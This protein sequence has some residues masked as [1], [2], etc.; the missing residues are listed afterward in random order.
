MSIP[1]TV[2]GDQPPESLAQLL[3]L[4][5]LRHPS[6]LAITFI[7]DDG[8]TRSLTYAELLKESLRTA[9]KLSQY[10]PAGSRG[11]L[12]YPP[13]IDFLIGFFGCSFAGWIPVPSCFPKA[14]RG[15]PRLDSIANNCNPS[16]LLLD[17]STL[18]MVDRSKWSAVASAL[19]YVTTDDIG[20]DCAGDKDAESCNNDSP[21]I[22]SDALQNLLQISPLALL[23]YTSGSTSEP[24]GVMVTHQNMMANLEAIREGFKI[25]FSDDASPTTQSS[26][27]WLPAFHDMGLI[28]GLLSPLYLGTHTVNFSPRAFLS[29]P[30]R[31]LELISQ[32]RGTITGAPNFAYQLCVD[33]IDGAQAEGLD[34]SCLRVAFCGAEPIQ[35]RT[36]EQF[37]SRFAH[38]GFSAHAIAP[39]YGLAESTLFVSGGRLGTDSLTIH[40]DRAKFRAG[41]IHIASSQHGNDTIRLV[42][43]GRASSDMEV[44][45]VDPSNLTALGECQ[46]GE[47]WLRGPSVAAGYWPMSDQDPRF[48][49]RILKQP[50]TQPNYCRTGDLGFLHSGHLYVTG[51][52]K[53]LIIL[54][55]RNHY[56]QDIE[57][58]VTK[59]M[60]S[61]CGAAAVFSSSG[62]AGE[63][64]CI[65][66]ETPR[67][68]ETQQLTEWS[69]KIR[70]DVIEEHEIDPRHLL[71]VRPGTVPMTTSGKVMRSSCKELFE[72]KS[73]ESRYRWDRSDVR[74]DGA[75]LPLPELPVSGSYQDVS[76]I[77]HS[78][79]QWLLSWLMIRGG[80][81][82]REINAERS[83]NDFG[84]DSLSA[85]EMSSEIEDWLG[86]RLTPL[87]AFEHPTPRALANYLAQTLAN[88]S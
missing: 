13:G 67:H 34:L 24:K 56:P 78:I 73:I 65:I 28:G 4:R 15:I 83:F 47:I 39:C 80:V 41:N 19:P 87:T 84:L 77:A 22:E 30:L 36:L 46:V 59:S 6:R 23:Q 53:D 75:P 82:Q 60:G 5:A 79:E 50:A 68:F 12:L 62:P 63:G 9:A 33:R 35:H 64:L 74:T 58:T 51:R 49:G 31:W 26:V 2:F 43:S 8:S 40:V 42:S 14:G 66:A 57:A 7:E 72:S 48:S 29:R 88:P 37:A 21:S 18:R 81:S 44:T 10:G 86:V 76:S 1:S 38:T 71:L 70:R 55:G 25:E 17:Q 61:D 85:I 20:C 16:A 54:R 45:I 32:Y 3:Q 11:L 69:R 52:L 27:F